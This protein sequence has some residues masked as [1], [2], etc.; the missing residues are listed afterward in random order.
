[1]PARREPRRHLATSP[2][3]PEP[4]QEVETYSVGD[5]V[6]HVRHGLG[7]VIATTPHT[8]TVQF[9]SGAV[10]VASPYARLTRL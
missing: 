4:V 9:A 7:A 1:V 10:R 5:R 2:F 6:S 3:R 8:V